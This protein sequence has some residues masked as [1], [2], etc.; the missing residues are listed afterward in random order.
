MIPTAITCSFE[1]H[2]YVCIPI[3][4]N[5]MDVCFFIHYNTLHMG[6]INQKTLVYLHLQG[7]DSM[8]VVPELFL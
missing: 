6:R 3:K 1:E 7:L 2:K 4:V 5:K 8:L